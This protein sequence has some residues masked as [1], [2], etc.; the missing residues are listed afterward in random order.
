MLITLFLCYAMQ[1][2]YY[3]THQ[4]FYSKRSLY[5]VVFRLEDGENGVHE[6]DSWL[7]EIQVHT[8]VDCRLSN[9]LISTAVCFCYYRYG[10]RSAL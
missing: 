8:V 2:Q 9:H 4:C 5:L 1:E 3:V 10:H 6:L 7:R